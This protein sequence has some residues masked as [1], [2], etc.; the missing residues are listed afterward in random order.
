MYGG[1][2][3]DGTRN[4]CLGTFFGFCIEMV[5]SW[6]GGQS[7]LLSFCVSVTQVG[8]RRDFYVVEQVVSD[9][10]PAGSLEYYAV[11]QCIIV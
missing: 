4:L 10:P 7:G 3:L 11:C 8:Y 2:D 6:G 9:T 1:S 5:F